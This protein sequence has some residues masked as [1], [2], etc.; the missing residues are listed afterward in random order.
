MIV[1]LVQASEEGFEGVEKG[2]EAEDGCGDAWSEHA[3]S[4]KLRE[5]RMELK[6]SGLIQADVC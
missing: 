4:A 3:R 2:E 5:D 1:R 6:R